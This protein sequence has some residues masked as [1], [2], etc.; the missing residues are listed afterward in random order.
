KLRAREIQRKG[1]ALEDF[2]TIDDLFGDAKSPV[3]FIGASG[4]FEPGKI[5][6]AEKAKH[7]KNAVE[8]VEQLLVWMPEDLLLYW[9]LG[10]ILNAEGDIAGAQMIF[11]ELVGEHKVRASDLRE[12]RRVLNNAK[13]PEPADDIQTSTPEQEDK[14]V[15]KTEPTSNLPDM[16]TLAV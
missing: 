12:R 4:K 8:I 6:V 9:L 11:E 16:R 7:P 14:P 10:E 3:K 2:D 1:K 5:A 13:L 15:S